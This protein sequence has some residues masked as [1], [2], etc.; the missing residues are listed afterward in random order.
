MFIKNFFEVLFKIKPNK[1][2]KFVCPKCGSPEVYLSSWMDS[3]LTPT[4]YICEKCGYRGPLLMKLE[5]E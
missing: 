1:K 5:E 4:Q 3:W 2:G